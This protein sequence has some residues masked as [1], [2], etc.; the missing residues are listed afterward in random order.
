MLS[1]HLDDAVF[2]AWH[3]L[4]QPAPVRVV[5]VFAGLPEAGGVTPLDR[6]HGAVDS[7]AWMRRRRA[8][9]LDVHAVTGCETIFLDLLDVQYRADQVP[10]IRAAMERDPARFLALVASEP[11]LQVDL[12]EMRVAVMAW[13]PPGVVVYTSTGIGGHPDHRDVARLGVELAREGWAVRLYADSPY[14]LRDGLPSWLGGEPNLP[15]DEAVDDAL[16]LL[17]PTYAGLRPQVV[18]LGLEQAA[19]KIDAAQRYMTEFR[20][21]DEDFEGIASEPE[22]MRHEAYWDLR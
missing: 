22:V 13:L 10:E 18:D 3:V 14:F 1:P 12:D 17:S 16:R 15:V 9:D 11:D 6:A 20:F 2:S 4:A 21:I 7:A 8:E 5:N 19:R